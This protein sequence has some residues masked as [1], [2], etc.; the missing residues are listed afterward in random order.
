MNGDK[1][2]Y[3]R[4]IGLALCLAFGAGVTLAP[5]PARAD[6]TPAP[7]ADEIHVFGV[8]D[9]SAP[10]PHCATLFVGSSSIR[11]WFGLKD[12]M[13]MP[14]VKRGFGGATIG[15]VNH[16]FDRVV[17][18]YTPRRIVFYAG[19]N[20]IDAGL[21]P[22]QTFAAFEEFMVRKQEALGATPVFFVS[23]KPSIARWHQ[24]DAQRSFNA[25]VA[26]LAARRADL[27]YIDVATPMLKD[28]APR[29]EIYIGDRLH[30]N[31]AGYA[32]WTKT[33]AHTLAHARTSK[34][35][36]CGR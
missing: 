2:H 16:Y 28:G 9:E 25:M 34:A 7:F 5:H 32:I 15:D 3:L 12:D 18:P 10:P 13:H 17:A 20:D 21:S 22:E 30:M 4:G 19:E 24:F 1:T 29:P 26:A 33:I 6:A 35:P 8:E 27:V 31:R 23:A 36:D 14:L 11:F